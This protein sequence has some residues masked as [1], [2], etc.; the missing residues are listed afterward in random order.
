MF[1]CQFMPSSQERLYD[2][3]GRVFRRADCLWVTGGPHFPG[4]VWS[5]CVG[6]RESGPQARPLYPHVSQLSLRGCCGKRGDAARLAVKAFTKNVSAVVRCT[7][8]VADSFATPPSL[9]PKPRR[10]YQMR[11]YKNSQKAAKNGAFSNCCIAL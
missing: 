10:R 7:Y 8:N 4:L 5:G 6:I 1:C 3:T 2:K 9:S 11:L